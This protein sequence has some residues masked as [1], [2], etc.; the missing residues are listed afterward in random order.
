MEHEAACI[1]YGKSLERDWHQLA[2]NLKKPASLTNSALEVTFQSR[3]TNVVVASSFVKL[4]KAKKVVPFYSQNVKKKKKKESGDIV[5][6]VNWTL[7]LR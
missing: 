1:F 5:L 7:D 6:S 4:Q 2:L 3:S